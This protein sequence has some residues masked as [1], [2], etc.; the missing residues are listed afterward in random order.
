M[1]PEDRDE[2]YLLAGE[3]VLGTLDAPAARE[4]ET[5]LSGN[6]ALRQAV[7]FWEE[8]LH[9][10]SQL[11]APAEPPADSWA[12]IAGRLGLTAAAPPAR[13]RLWES[14]AFW[15]WSTAG[16]TALAA[17]L[18][19]YIAFGAPAA[20]R[21]VAV[22]HAPQQQHPGWVL[23]GS[24]GRL[25]L[26]AVVAEGPPGDR[27]FELWAIPP[28]QAPMSLGV[29]PAG[30]R[31]ELGRGAASLRDGDQLAI[32]IEPKGGSPTGQPTGPI[33]FAGALVEAK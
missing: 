6:A 7:A 20:P 32:S 33:V 2:L 9:G 14:V 3:Y 10:L 12:K 16:V 21:F 27:S 26:R 5:A 13:T 18:V 23:T 1:I 15:R 25:L 4:I 19:L 8:R 31:F 17:A 11:A 28:G 24:G 22:L 29:I 30:G